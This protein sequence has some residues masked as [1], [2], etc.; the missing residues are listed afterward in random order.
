MKTLNNE[1]IMNREEV[2]GAVACIMGCAV[3]AFLQEALDLH[4]V[5][6]RSYCKL[7]SIT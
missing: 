2:G 6:Q 7:K 4:L 3:Y 1:T 5:Q